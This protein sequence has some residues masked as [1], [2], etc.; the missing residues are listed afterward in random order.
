[1]TYVDQS[2][3]SNDEFTFVSYDSTHPDPDLD[4]SDRDQEWHAELQGHG[5]HGGAGASAAAREHRRR[6]SPIRRRQAA[7]T[8]DVFVPAPPAHETNKP[9]P[10][11][12]DTL[13]P[14]GPS[15]PGSSLALIL[16]ALATLILGL[17]FVTPVPAAV[18]RRNRR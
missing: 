4:R 7:T 3:T 13:A 10:P 5:R 12:T 1:M 2:A 8:S 17:S 9:T 18:R 15:N 14:T 11:P 16:A 6:S